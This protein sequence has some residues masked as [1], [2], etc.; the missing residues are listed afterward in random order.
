LRYQARVF[1]PESG[2]MNAGK[3]GQL[4]PEKRQMLFTRSNDNIVIHRLKL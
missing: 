3:S 1:H 4:F 2:E